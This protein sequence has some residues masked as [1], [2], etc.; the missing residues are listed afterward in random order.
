MIAAWTQLSTCMQSLCLLWPPLSRH[1]PTLCSWPVPPVGVLHHSMNVFYNETPILASL[2]NLSDAEPSPRKTSTASGPARFR[3]LK[4]KLWGKKKRWFMQKSCWVNNGRFFK[5]H[6]LS[7]KTID[8]REPWPAK[9]VLKKEERAVSVP[10][11]KHLPWKD[12]G[13]E[14]VLSF[15]SCAP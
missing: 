6:C 13:P 10:A 11:G 12:W 8:Q 2:R 7:H 1:Q 14:E 5:E 15:S 4:G 9:G 3:S